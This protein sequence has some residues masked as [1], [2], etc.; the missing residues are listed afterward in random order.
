MKLT[1]VHIENF[2][3]IKECDFSLLDP[4]GRPWDRFCLVG[5]NGSGKTTVL[6]A[7]ALVLGMA[8][9]KV[10]G[11]NLD[12]PGF[13]PDTISSQGQTRIELTVR[14]TDEE[15]S[16]QHSVLRAAPR[17]PDR[18]A[19][20]AKL[21]RS[22][23]VVFEHGEKSPKYLNVEADD[24]APLLHK[25]LA[26]RRIA[27][28]GVDKGMVSL[29]PVVGQL[30]EVVWVLQSRSLNTIVPAFEEYTFQPD[31]QWPTPEDHLREILVTWHS[32]SGSTEPAPWD[33]FRELEV[34]LQ[35]VLDG[36]R[37]VTIEPRRKG[38]SPAARDVDIWLRRNGIRYELAEM[39]SGEQA[40]FALVYQFAQERVANSVCLVDE[41]ELHLHMPA[42]Q[43]LYNAL[44][45]L[46]EDCQ[47]ILTTHSEFLV[48]R[49]HPDQ[50]HRLPGGVPCL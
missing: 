9:R 31:R 30:A 19:E 46:G 13:R 50:I 43:V 37:I 11:S 44:P 8:T 18:I 39:S 33:A 2:K 3:G 24:E 12:W 25:Q 45:K 48:D 42:Q 22:G 26:A 16:L 4:D 23:R 15:L 7:I 20:D 27:Q 40:V 38:R 14:F 29:A 36:T 35:R 34:R 6:Q 28:A 1:H 32:A 17:G 21:A 47:F 5:D 10:D 41:L 49:V